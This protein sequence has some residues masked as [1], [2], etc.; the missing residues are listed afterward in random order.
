[1]F[2]A[3]LHDRLAGEREDGRA[4][5]HPTIVVDGQNRPAKTC[6]APVDTCWHDC[7]P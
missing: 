4:L 3:D 1:M 2:A 7:A 5:V 6:G